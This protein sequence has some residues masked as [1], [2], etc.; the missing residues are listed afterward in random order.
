MISKSSLWLWQGVNVRSELLETATTLLP[1]TFSRI[2]EVLN[3]DSVSMAI[4]FYSTFVK[5]VHTE[6]DVSILILF[7]V[8]G[9]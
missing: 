8:I 9:I 4:S 7:M 5:D 2:L 1:V 3:S 6:K